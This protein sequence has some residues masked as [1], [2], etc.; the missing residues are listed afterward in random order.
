M[1]Q[2]AVIAAIFIVFGAFLGGWWVGKSKA[3]DEISRAESLL[4]A[5][6]R[7]ALR[8]AAADLSF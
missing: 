4:P 7:A 5:G 8:E 1:K 2:D 3:Y 6:C